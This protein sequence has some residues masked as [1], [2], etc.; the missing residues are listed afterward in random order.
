[1]PL[2]MNVRHLRDGVTTDEVATAHKA[3]VV[4]EGS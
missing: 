2:L 3:D 4:R 1:M